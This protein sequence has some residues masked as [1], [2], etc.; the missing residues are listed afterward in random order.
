MF[1]ATM[2]KVIVAAVAVSHAAGALRKTAPREGML[3]RLRRVS[4]LSSN[5]RG[6]TGTRKQPIEGLVQEALASGVDGLQSA[7]LDRMAMQNNGQF[8]APTINFA[9]FRQVPLVATPLPQNVQTAVNQ[10]IAGAPVDA[11]VAPPA[12]V[13]T[14]AASVTAPYGV[15][16]A[17]VTTT[18]APVVV[19]ASATTAP[20]V[21]G[22]TTTANPMLPTTTGHIIIIQEPCP[23]ECPR[24]PC[25]E[26]KKEEVPCPAECSCK[27]RDQLG[28]APAA[29]L[30][31]ELVGPEAP[32]AAQVVAAPAAPPPAAV[33][34][35]QQAGTTTLAP[36]APVVPN[37][38]ATLPPGMMG[39]G[40]LPLVM[41]NIDGGGFPDSPDGSGSY[42]AA[43]T[44]LE[45]FLRAVSDV[46][47]CTALDEKVREQCSAIP[48]YEVIDQF[49]R[50]RDMC[51]SNFNRFQELSRIFIEY[52]GPNANCDTIIELW[53]IG[54]YESFQACK[55]ATRNMEFRSLCG[56]WR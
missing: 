44:H 11:A 45:S 31:A 34:C 30:R 51:M 5:V 41:P 20:A 12:P 36:C 13:V 52:L 4:L 56:Q 22:M 9:D 26:K 42:A 48:A 35:V 21:A 37:A 47:T 3:D 53:R 14:A 46:I 17:I 27:L 55:D 32:A 16:G 49:E 38:M 24:T 39:N 50:S 18:A 10:V 8:P 15:P 2:L 6:Q 28:P 23:A 19:A 25:E 7:A 29:A 33:P 43:K 40:Q 54:G 1:C